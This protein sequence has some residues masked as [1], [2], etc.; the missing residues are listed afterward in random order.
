MTHMLVLCMYIHVL[1]HHEGLV[2]LLFHYL[3]TYC[4]SLVPNAIFSSLT[5]LR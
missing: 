5:I 1:G 2:L 3:V 4:E